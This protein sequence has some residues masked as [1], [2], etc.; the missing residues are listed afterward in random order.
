MDGHKK[1]RPSLFLCFIDKIYALIRLK[2]H[3]LGTLSGLV[4]HYSAQ[5][6][7]LKAYFFRIS[8]S[9]ILPTS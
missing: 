8:R 1:D 4:I 2:Y 5:S 7:F 6:V 9:Y 3:F